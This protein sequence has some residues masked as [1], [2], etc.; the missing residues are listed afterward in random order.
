MPHQHAEYV[1]G[2]FGCKI[3]TL[4]FG[5]VPGGY[6]DMNDTTRIS[7]EARDQITHSDGEPIFSEERIR[8]AES[9]VREAYRDFEAMQA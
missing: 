8:D 6:R 1:E 2:C 5:T 3:R 4:S 7:D 9:H